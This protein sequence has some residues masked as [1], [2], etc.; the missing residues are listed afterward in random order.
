MNFS[1]LP[2][3]FGRDPS[4]KSTQS[5]V[6]AGP[7][8]ASRLRSPPVSNRCRP[9]RGFRPT[10]SPLK[11]KRCYYVV[12]VHMSDIYCILYTLACIR[13]YSIFAQYI[14]IFIYIYIYIFIYIYIYLYIYIHTVLSYLYIYTVENILIKHIVFYIYIY[15][16]YIYIYIIYYIAL[17][18]TYN[19]LLNNII[20]HRHITSYITYDLLSMKWCIL[21]IAYCNKY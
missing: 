20:S 15:I 8:P 1:H 13:V 5:A 17:N 4:P 3:I 11:N 2:R 12:L 19:I 7:P 18:Q 6:R 14:Y 16:I 9:G 21:C 10:G